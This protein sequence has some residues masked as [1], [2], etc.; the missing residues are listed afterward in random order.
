ME[1]PIGSVLHIREWS[2]MAEE[3]GVD[4]YGDIICP[5]DE[6]FSQDMEFLCGKVFTVKEIYEEQENRLYLSEEGDEYL[7][8]DG[9]SDTIPWAICKYMFKEFKD[10]ND[11]PPIDVDDF[12][13]V[14]QNA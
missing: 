9:T 10:A 6:E 11:S 5:D 8:E 1:F 2:D 7:Y 13:E 12:M 4:D 3:Y 14:L